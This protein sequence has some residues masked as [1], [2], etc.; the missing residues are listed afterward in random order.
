MCV[1]SKTRSHSGASAHHRNE[2]INWSLM[3]WAVMMSTRQQGL[4]N[5]VKITRNESS[6]ASFMDGSVLYTDLLFYSLHACTMC[7][8]TVRFVVHCPPSCRR[9]EVAILNAVKEALS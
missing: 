7:D 6:D 9:R 4:S 8:S 1:C 3:C 5:H 2:E